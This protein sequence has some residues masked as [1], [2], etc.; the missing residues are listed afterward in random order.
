MLASPSMSPGTC[1]RSGTDQEQLL[2]FQGVHT[3]LLSIRFGGLKSAVRR[4]T[5]LFIQDSNPTIWRKHPPMR[6]H[7]LGFN[8]VTP[9]MSTAA[10]WLIQVACE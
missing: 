8:R 3:Y 9:K 10:E 2:P 4:L 7:S 1:L 6:R 5:N